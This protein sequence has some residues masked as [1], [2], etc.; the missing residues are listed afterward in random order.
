MHKSYKK[1][2]RDATASIK[3]GAKKT[4]REAMLK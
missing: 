2:Y 3:R 1:H 4:E